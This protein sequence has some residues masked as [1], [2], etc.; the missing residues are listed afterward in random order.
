MSTSEF[1][2]F[3]FCEKSEKSGFKYKTVLQSDSRKITSKWAWCHSHIRLV[4]WYIAGY[5]RLVIGYLQ[6]W[7]RYPYGICGRAMASWIVRW[8]PDR[9]VLVGALAGGIM[10]CYW[11]HTLL[12]VPFSTLMP[13]QQWQWNCTPS[14]GRK[15]NIP[16]Y[17]MQQ[18]S[19]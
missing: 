8:T 6:F 18:K 5:C 9:A 14:R 16:S 2:K 12:A 4:I 13:G 3:H 19:E 11:E 10:F 1:S 17:F 7:V 15:R